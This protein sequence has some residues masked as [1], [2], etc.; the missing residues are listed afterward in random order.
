MIKIQY[1]FLKK[2]T[3]KLDNIDMVAHSSLLPTLVILFLEGGLV[4]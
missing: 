3:V 1:F 2:K 4:L